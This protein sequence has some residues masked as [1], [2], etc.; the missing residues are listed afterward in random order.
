M[1]W[2]LA[3]IK[4]PTI[5]CNKCI[6]SAWLENHIRSEGKAQQVVCVV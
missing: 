1:R 3:R 2:W 6:T 4:Y 5:G